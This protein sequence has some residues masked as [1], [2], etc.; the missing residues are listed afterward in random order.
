VLCRPGDVCSALVTFA[1]AVLPVLY[2]VHHRVAACILQFACLLSVSAGMRACA[3]VCLPPQLTGLNIPTTH[4][5]GC[6]YGPT[7]TTG[8]VVGCCLNF[9]DMT[10]FYTKNGAK[11]GEIE[12]GVG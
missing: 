1:V 12:C 11:L 8:D 10:C 7:F 2:W 3:R 6:S 4:A 5:C 9:G